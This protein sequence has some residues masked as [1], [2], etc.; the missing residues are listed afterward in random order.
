MVSVRKAIELLRIAGACTD[1][2]EQAA[3]GESL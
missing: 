2:F 1:P 3:L